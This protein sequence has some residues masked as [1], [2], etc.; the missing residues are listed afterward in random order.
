MLWEELNARNVNTVVSV[1]VPLR[2]D[3]ADEH[4]R[5]GEQLRREKEADEAENRI[6]V[7]PQTAERMQEVEAEARASE[8][9]FSFRSVGRGAYRQLVSK[10]PASA[11]AEDVTAAAE[12]AGVGL[13]WNPDTFPPALLAASCL[14]IETA[15]GEVVDIATV[16]WMQLWQEWS[17]GVTERLWRACQAANAGVGDAPKSVAASATIASSAKS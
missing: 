13:L 10:H 11:A 6:P 14:R 5:L 3:L 9:T 2:G 1:T 17:S 4:D 15:A 7:A 12:K 8:A 16:D